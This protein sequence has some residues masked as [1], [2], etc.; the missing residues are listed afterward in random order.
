MHGNDGRHGSVP[1]IAVSFR[2]KTAII[3]DWLVSK[4]GAERI[5]RPLLSILPSADIYALVCDRESFAAETAGHRVFTSGLQHIPGIFRVY[6]SLVPLFPSLIEKFDL[7]GYDLVLSVSHCV[8]KGVITPPDTCHIC[9]C[10]TPV[11]YAWELYAD[12]FSPSR[13]NAINGFQRRLAPFVMNYLKIWD[14]ASSNRVD[15]FLSVSH[16]IARKVRKYYRRESDVVYPPV[17]TE[18]FRPAGSPEDFFLVVSRLVPYK[19]VDVIVEAFN[20]LRLPLKIVGTGPEYRR[21]TR[22]AGTN[23]EFLGWQPDTVVRDLY[24]SCRALVVAAEEDFGITPLEAQASGRPVIALR[25]GGF[26][27]TVVEGTSGVLFDRQEAGSLAEAVRIFERMSFDTGRIRSHALQ[28]SPDVFA[29]T[30]RERIAAC[31]HEYAAMLR[32]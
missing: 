2:M 23:V 6:R 20:R 11:R 24:A 1:P 30:M 3:Y 12:Y 28:F 18:F 21:L 29:R 26:R 25:R 5:V 15:F 14:A 19:R 16:N 10:L 13:R 17:D 4:G 22:M 32:R 31:M 9:Y 27:E 7:R 8:A